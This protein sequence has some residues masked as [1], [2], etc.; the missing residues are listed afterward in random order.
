MEF[1]VK[2]GSPEKRRTPALVVGVFANRSLSESAALLDQACGGMIT[3]VLRRGDMEGESG[4]VLWLYDLPNISADRVLLIGCGKAEALNEA[5]FVRILAAMTRALQQSGAAEAVSYLCELT[6]KQYD[7]QWKLQQSVLVIEDTLYRFDQFKQKKEDTKR[8][9]KR[10]IFGLPTRNN[11]PQGEQAVREASAMATG[12]R[13][14]KDLGNLPGNICTP[15]YLAEQAQQLART[16]T[17]L[18]VS[19]LEEAELEALGMQALLAVTKGTEQPAKFIIVE[20]RKGEA[21]DKPVVLVGKGVTF[22]SGGISLKPGEA[23]DEMKYDM[24]GAASVLGTLLACA[25]LMLPINLIGVIPAVENMPSGKATRPGDIVTTLSGQSVE[26]LNTD[27]EGRLI[28]CDALT[29]VER[30]EP[31]VVIDIATLTGACIIALGHQGCALFSNQAALAQDLREAGQQVYD[32]AWE[33]PLW[34]EY[35]EQLKSNFADMAN[36]GGR[37]AGSITAACFLARFTKK[38]AWAHLDIAG[39]AWKSGKEKG[40]TGRPVPLLLRYLLNRL[41]SRAHG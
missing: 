40:A 13:L 5:T 15:S 28:L 22:D 35:Q 1:L 2:S 27:A 14:T 10:V 8:P 12:M 38:Y 24:C 3:S 37:P 6:V 41:H 34:E 30:F 36:I 26:I 32:R 11:L 23:M 17:D 4:Q 16:Y 31:E 20:Y 21:K 39:V 33:M 29:Y 18:A 9:L 7:M 19:V 25:E